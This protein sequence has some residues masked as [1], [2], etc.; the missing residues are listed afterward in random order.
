MNLY[1]KEAEHR[2][3]LSHYVRKAFGGYSL[4]FT[5]A[6]KEEFLP[7][8]GTHST[9]NDSFNVNLLDT[10]DGKIYKTKLYVAYEHEK[11]SILNEEYDPVEAESLMGYFYGSHHCP[12]HRKAD[13]KRA[14]AIV[15]DNECEGNRFLIHSITHDKV[16]DVILYSEVF[17]EDGLEEMLK[18]QT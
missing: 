2:K 14:G 10:H 11:E 16:P 8:N 7:G 5:T 15:E 6:W 1:L 12:C 18:S 17:D 13:A 3:W 4:V 9:D